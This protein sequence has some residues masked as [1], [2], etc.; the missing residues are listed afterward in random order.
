MYV[1]VIFLSS[2]PSRGQQSERDV[3][4]R[5]LVEAEIDGAALANQLTALKETIDSLAKVNIVPTECKD[6]KIIGSYEIFA[7]LVSHLF[8]GSFR[9]SCSQNRTQLLWGGSR[10]CC[11]RRLRCLVTRITEFESS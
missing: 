10:S 3:L 7:M 11:W 2:L 6:V 9:R 4:L 8:L 1:L 5:A